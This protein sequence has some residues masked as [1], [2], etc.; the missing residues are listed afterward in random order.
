MKIS[1]KECQG[2]CQVLYLFPSSL[3]IYHIIMVCSKSLRYVLHVIL[4]KEGWNK[5]QELLLQMKI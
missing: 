2:F 4:K 1:C 3:F 5:A